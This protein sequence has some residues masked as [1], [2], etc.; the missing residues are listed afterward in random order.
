MKITKK[1]AKINEKQE[2]I[3]T[4]LELL[5]PNDLVYTSLKSASSSGMSRQIAVY[6][7]YT[8]E[9]GQERIKDI[10]WLVGKALDLK[11]GSKG[12]LVVGGCGMGFHVVYGLGRT[13][14]PNGTPEPHGKRNGVPD[15][16]GGYA[17]KHSWL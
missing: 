15:S 7:A 9:Q 10:T 11:I 3:N 16:D 1:Q 13:L 5:K 12:G 8:N 4:L 2:H 6:I 14:W 17:L